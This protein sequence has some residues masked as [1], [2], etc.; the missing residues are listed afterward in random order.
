M[1]A[2]TDRIIALTSLEGQSVEVRLR[3]TSPGISND[4]LDTLSGFALGG[5]P[6]KSPIGDLA[7]RFPA[8][9]WEEIIKP[10]L[11]LKRQAFNVVRP[12]DKHSGNGQLKNKIYLVEDDLETLFALNAMLEEAG[13]D[14]LLSHCAG[15]LME[16]RLP[17]TDLFI[18]DRCIPDVDGLQICKKLRQ[19]KDTCNTPVIMISASDEKR[20][21]AAA[22]G[23]NEFILKPFGMHE[24]LSTI[25]RYTTPYSLNALPG[26]AQ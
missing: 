6:I 13:Y 25:S 4:I 15:P 12:Q 14:V 18:L 21:E 8:L 26:A 19:R 17:Q 9:E 5:G 7:F 16:E 1:H 2:H 3:K 22:A 24:L 20:R 23:V 11:V 10:F